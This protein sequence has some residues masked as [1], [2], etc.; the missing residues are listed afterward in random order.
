MR[1]SHPLTRGLWPLALAA[2]MAGPALG[3]AAPDIVAGPD[4]A[5]SAHPVEAPIDEV[6]VF[7]DRARVIRRGAL[8]PGRGL[9]TLRLPDLPGGALIETVR[10]SA[11]GAK[12]LRV[13]AAP[14]EQDQVAIAEVEALLTAIEAIDDQRAE[15]QMARQVLDAEADLLTRLTPIPA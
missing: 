11:S 6:L 1:R 9:R 10:L 15:L 12:V 13:E 4:L 14:V 8:A 3:A 7:S 2:M 5:N